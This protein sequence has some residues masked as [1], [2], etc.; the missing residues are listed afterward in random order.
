M[1]HKCGGGVG[2]G[3]KEGSSLQ[4]DGSPGWM[5]WLRL[6]CWVP[7]S[8]PWQQPFPEQLSS[9]DLNGWPKCWV[10][11]YLVACFLTLM[12]GFEHLGTLFWEKQAGKYFRFRMH[13]FLNTQGKQLHCHEHQTTGKYITLKSPIPKFSAC[14]VQILSF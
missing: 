5:W 2:K 14:F 13:L 6:R 11:F 10:C 4:R 3:R 9:S 1:N 8:N 7:C 12:Y